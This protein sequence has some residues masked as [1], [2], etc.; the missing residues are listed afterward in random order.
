VLGPSGLMTQIGS[1]EYS[2]GL[3]FRET[4]NQWLTTIGVMWLRVRLG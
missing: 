1:I 4:F 2:R 3:R